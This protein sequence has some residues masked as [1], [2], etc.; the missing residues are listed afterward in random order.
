MDFLKIFLPVAAMALSLGLL[1]AFSVVL[2]PLFG[3]KRKKATEK[4]KYYL[5]YADKK[6]NHTEPAFYL[7]AD[8]I[9]LRQADSSY[10]LSEDK[11]AVEDL[12][13]IGF[14]LKNRKNRKELEFEPSFNK[15]A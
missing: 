15:S 12:M 8:S 1:F 5:T 13:E 9:R 7:D 11:D 2:T 14:K 10:A 4:P 6:E 3:K